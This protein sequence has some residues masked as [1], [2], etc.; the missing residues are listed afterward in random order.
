[1]VI[2]EA[3]LISAYE[4]SPSLIIDQNS[5]VEMVELKLD[6]SPTKLKT[7]LVSNQEDRLLRH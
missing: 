1:V 7:C 2:D 3:S 4:R 5:E 6:F